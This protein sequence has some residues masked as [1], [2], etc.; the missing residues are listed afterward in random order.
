[1]HP[2]NKKIASPPQKIPVPIIAIP[3][4]AFVPNVN[5]LPA[6]MPPKE[7]AISETNTAQ[8]ETIADHSTA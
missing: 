6:T 2:K 7:Q 5:A 1:M 3:T 8:I 4:G